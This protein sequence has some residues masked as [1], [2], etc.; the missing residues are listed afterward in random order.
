MDKIDKVIK[1]VAVICSREIRSTFIELDKL[2]LD[3]EDEHYYV[4]VKR[5]YIARKTMNYLEGNDEHTCDTS[6]E[7]LVNAIEMLVEEQL[8][9]MVKKTA[10]YGVTTNKKGE[11]LIIFRRT[12]AL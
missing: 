2:G 9:D 8:Y 5:E 1:D 3:V 7:L 4:E 12:N 11:M 6:N 10:G